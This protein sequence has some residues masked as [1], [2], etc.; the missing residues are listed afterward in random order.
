MSSEKELKI[1]EIDLRDA[2]FFCNNTGD[3]SIF[4][5]CNIEISFSRAF[6]AENVDF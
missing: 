2:I 4:S 3:S 5:G 1:R 6:H